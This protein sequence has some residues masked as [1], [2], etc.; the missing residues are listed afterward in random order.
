MQ[1]DQA[2][3]LNR[4]CDGLKDVQSRLSLSRNLGDTQDS[5]DRL[6]IH[7]VQ[8]LRE[9]LQQLSLSEDSVQK[10]Q[11]ILESLTFTRRPGRHA[12]IAEAHEETFKWALMTTNDPPHEPSIGDWLQNGDG[13]FC[14]SGKPGSGKSTL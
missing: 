7:D 1:T 2:N 11:A 5:G 13:I 10:Q 3:T 4:I 14:V 9:K 12:Q 6:T 8:F